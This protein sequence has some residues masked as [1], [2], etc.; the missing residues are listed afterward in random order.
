MRR[1]SWR[2]TCSRPRLHVA[3]IRQSRLY[4][5][6]SRSH[7]KQS[8]PHIRQSRPAKALKPFKVVPS[9]FGRCI[10]RFS[11]RATSSRPRLA[12]RIS[13]CSTRQVPGSEL[14]VQG[15][16]AH[17]K[18]IPLGLYNRPMPSAVRLWPHGYPRAPPFRFW[19]QGSGYRGTSLR[20][21]MPPS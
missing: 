1:S 11:W 12:T 17:T 14:R 15:Y 19:V 10:G 20:S 16:L 6:Q 5:R 8:R 2:A 18:H 21:N 9:S 13:A 3:H 7:I 4:I